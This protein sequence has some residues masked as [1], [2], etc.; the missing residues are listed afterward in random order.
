MASSVNNYDTSFET[1]KTW[2]TGDAIVATGT[3]GLNNQL[4]DEL[5]A[6]AKPARGYSVIDE[7]SDYSVASSSSFA[8]VDSTYLKATFTPSG[9]GGLVIVHFVG[10]FQSSSG[11][12]TTR[13]FLN[14]SVDGTNQ[15]ADD[16]ILVFTAIN[17]VVVTVAFA[18]PIPG[19]DNTQHIFK[20][21]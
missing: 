6:L 13:H 8:D 7:A 21:R 2:A 19:L 5:L 20:L 1:P 17:P 16:G 11:L 9:Q 18:L 4:R 10:S 12:N 3:D 14:V 15:V